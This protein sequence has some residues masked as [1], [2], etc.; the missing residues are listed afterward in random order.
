VVHEMTQLQELEH[1]QDRLERPIK[2]LQGK[3]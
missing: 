1:S 3:W 2:I